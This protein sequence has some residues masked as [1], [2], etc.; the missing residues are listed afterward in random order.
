MI[1]KIWLTFDFLWKCYLPRKPSNLRN[2]FVKY[3][4]LLKRKVKQ[5]SYWQ[6]QK[7]NF[8]RKIGPSIA[9]S[10]SICQFIVTP[11][12]PNHLPV[13]MKLQK[14][15]FRVE[16]IRMLSNAILKAVIYSNFLNDVEKEEYAW[17]YVFISTS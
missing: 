11:F 5:T 16:R 2:S 12:G 13:A 10:T 3:L 6:F 7:F 9:I 17:V 4:I 15:V 8:L 14:L 1:C